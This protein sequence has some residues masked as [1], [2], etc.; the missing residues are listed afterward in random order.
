MVIRTNVTAGIDRWSSVRTTRQPAR[1]QG[2][3]TSARGDCVQKDDCRADGGSGASTIRSIS[4][5]VSRTL[6]TAKPIR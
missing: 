3:A 5:N 1:S 2:R 6:S 4:G